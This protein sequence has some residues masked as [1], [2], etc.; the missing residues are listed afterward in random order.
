MNANELLAALRDRVPGGSF[1]VEYDHGR[2]AVTIQGRGPRVGVRA[3]VGEE[4]IVAQVSPDM[5]MAD[6]V[7]TIVEEMQ[8]TATHEYGLDAYVADQR[9]IAADKALRAAMQVI[10]EMIHEIDER[11]S[12]LFGPALHDAE[13]RA[14]LAIA[15]NKIGRIET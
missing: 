15:L 13:R 11:A 8:R 12:R 9:D 4:F 3:G 7:R 2:Q 10:T 14:S 1:V 5:A 6:F